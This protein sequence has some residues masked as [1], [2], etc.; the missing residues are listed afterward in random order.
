MGLELNKQFIFWRTRSH[1]NAAIKTKK[2]KKKKVINLIKNASIETVKK[3]RPVD[4]NR[5]ETS[6]P[7]STASMEYKVSGQ[8]LAL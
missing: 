7:L 2:K 8:L 4:E 6:S 1:R 5:K 3:D